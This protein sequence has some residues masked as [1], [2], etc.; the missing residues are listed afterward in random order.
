LFDAAVVE[1][2]AESDR[3]LREQCRPLLERLVGIAERLAQ[4]WRARLGALPTPA[5]GWYR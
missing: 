4:P 5:D 2:E 1:D 3:A